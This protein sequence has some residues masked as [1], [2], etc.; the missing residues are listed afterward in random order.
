MANELVAAARR[1]GA[2]ALTDAFGD[3]IR[4]FVR[5]ILVKEVQ[6]DGTVSVD[7]V[8]AL[9]K[10]VRRGDWL[11]LRRV[12]DAPDAFVVA[13]L[14][15]AGE[16]IGFVSRLEREIVARL[17]DAGKKMKAKVVSKRLDGHW[18]DMRLGLYLEDV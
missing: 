15:A 7:D 10:D 9:A 12:K 1:G 8:L 18:L 13:V 6:L 2:L 4:P 17:M 14:N 5:D 11:A 16:T 3:V